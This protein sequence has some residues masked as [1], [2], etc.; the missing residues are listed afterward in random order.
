MKMSVAGG[1][2]VVV[3]LLVLQTPQLLSQKSDTTAMLADDPETWRLL[4]TADDLKEILKLQIPVLEEALKSSGQLSRL[5]H[6][7][8]ANSGV[9]AVL[10]NIGTVVLEGE[11]ALKSASLRDA[12]LD[13]AQAADKRDLAK[14]KS[15]LERIAGYPDKIAPAERAETKPWTELISS[16]SIMKQVGAV[17][18]VAGK[19]N[20]ASPRDFRKDAK[21]AA[22]QTLLLTYLTVIARDHQQADDWR[23]WCDQ[24]RADALKLAKAYYKS[25]QEAA[26]EAYTQL[27]QSCDA[28][29]KVYRSN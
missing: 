14:A 29:H 9:I 13:L 23:G 1:F 4:A 18:T 8:I 15:A 3:I 21:S 19:A 20:R 24:M 7:T 25:N 17:N 6:Q 11:D 26:R 27:Q 28:C 12:G 5:R 16:E 10:G 2:A 22:Y